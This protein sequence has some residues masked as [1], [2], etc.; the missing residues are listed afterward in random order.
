TTG[1]AEEVSLGSIGRVKKSRDVVLRARHRD[2]DADPEAIYWR[3][4]T[5]TTWT[6]DGWRDERGLPARALRLR[7]NRRVLLDRSAANDET[8]DLVVDVRLESARVVD[9]IVPDRA[10]WIESGE[11]ATIAADD[12]GTPRAYRGGAP[13]RYRVASS[14]SAPY[15][16]VPP[17]AGLAE[18][19]P[20]VSEWAASVAPGESDPRALA[21]ALV[22]DLSGRE[23]SLDTRGID[24]SR[25]IASFLEGAPAHCEYFA[26]AMALGLRLRDVPSRVVGGYIGADRLPLVRELVVRAERAHLWVEAFLPDRGW[27]RFDPTPAAGRAPATGAAVSLRAFADWG[28]IAWDSWVIGLDLGDQQTLLLEALDLLRGTLRLFRR[29]LPATILLIAVAAAVLV[30]KRRDA[31]RGRRGL[32]PYYRRMLVL[33]R[34]RGLVPEVA[35][36]PGEFAT[37]AAERFRDS[38]AVSVVTRLYERERFGERSPTRRELAEAERALARLAHER[39]M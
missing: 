2:G 32:P 37:R 31:L 20:A 21:A 29:A 10:V 18:V 22:S 14:A 15:P 34:G 24:P 25:P 8:P 6:G 16:S 9:L 5:F 35:E 11:H 27:V 17:D 3:A 38:G 39:A 23:Y 19:D 13:R 7:P 36:T 33:A 1:I 12:D 4:R 26:S 28:V 30:A